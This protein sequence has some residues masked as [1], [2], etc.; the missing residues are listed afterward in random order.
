VDQILERVRDNGSSLQLRMG[1][2]FE[3]LRTI[4]GGE[5]CLAALQPAGEESYAT[6]VICN[7]EGRVTETRALME[8]SHASLHAR[9]A[10][11][12]T[13][14]IHNRQVTIY[15]IPGK[16][17]PESGHQVFYVVTQQRLIVT[18]HP[19]AMT[20]ILA[21]WA[22]DSLASLEDQPAFKEVLQ[23]T[24]L[25]DGRIQPQL[26]WYVEPFGYARLVRAAMG[27]RKR[28]TDLLKLLQSQ[29]FDAL[30]AVGG[31]VALK[32]PDHEVLHRT[33]VYAP[34][35]RTLAA[36]MLDFPMGPQM[37]PV[38]WVPRNV[39]NYVSFRWQMTDAFDYS[40]SLVNAVA[41]CEDFFKDFLRDLEQDEDGPQVNLR[42]DLI[43]HLGDQITFISDMQQ[44]V[45]PKSD[46]FLVAVEVT[47]TEAVARTVAQFLQADPTAKA[48]E[49]NG[50]TIWEIIKEQADDDLDLTVD[51]E[52]DGAKFDFGNPRGDKTQE[53][54][55]APPSLPNSAI[56]VVDGKLLVSSHLEMIVQVVQQMQQSASES[57]AQSSDY[58]RV[59]AALDKL[60]VGSESFRI[61][62]RSDET[63]HATYELIRQ[64]RVGESESLVARLLNRLNG[65]KAA[66]KHEQKIDGSQL[67]GYEYVRKYLGPVGA[68]VETQGDG[69]MISGFLLSQQAN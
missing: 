20:A 38:D 69:W 59:S 67:P 18:D 66:A 25:D 56:A 8:K 6:V 43:A 48:H 37:Q 15:A 62:S 40:E 19:E 68:V 63:Y 65:E 3:D 1:I 57:L 28:G 44:P 21:R 51:V 64:N 30:E 9:K 17:G 13:K 27:Q 2:S 39:S 7:V 33:L 45:T 26:Y 54:E 4:S 50:L 55:E 16:Y 58:N 32:T 10:T 60:A 29:G 22:D 31:Q 42:R 34:K 35:E 12:Q 11:Q 49:I 5:L 46:R 47:D 14:T 41:K 53:T 61:F 36:R 24:G 52:V 23:R